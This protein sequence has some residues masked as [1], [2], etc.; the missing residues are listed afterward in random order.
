[1]DLTDIYRT[2][3]PTPKEN[4]SAPHGT[5]FKTEHISHK[6]SLERCKKIEITLSILPEH[7]G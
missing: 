3:H 6:L 7:H 1:M 4:T 2:F 5:F